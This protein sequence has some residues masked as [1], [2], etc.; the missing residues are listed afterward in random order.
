MRKQGYVY[1]GKGV[2]SSILTLGLIKK[3][4]NNS[5]LNNKFKKKLNNQL[6]N[7]NEKNIIFSDE[8]LSGFE[9]TQDYIVKLFELY[10]KL[11]EGHNVV[12]IIYIRRID[13]YL[14]SR[15]KYCFVK[16]FN[17][18]II[19]GQ[20][21]TFEEYVESYINSNKY[22]NY[23]TICEE[24]TKKFSETALSIRIMEIN[25]FENLFLKTLKQ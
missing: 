19:D 23:V 18:Y 17:N 9:K 2:D 21:S 5:H 3:L 8:G 13:R 1:K 4:I 25:N 11:F 10:K 22:Y 6:N 7:L 14:E 20:T 24:I 12:F 15:Y 16:R